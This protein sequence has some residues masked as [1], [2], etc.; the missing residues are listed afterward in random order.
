VEKIGVGHL[1]F[2]S[3]ALETVH[4]LSNCPG[5]LLLGA[6][7]AARAD[8]AAAGAHVTQGDGL[9]ESQ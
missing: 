8:S 2:E 3:V 4:S 6:L 5:A 9:S 1:Q 7:F